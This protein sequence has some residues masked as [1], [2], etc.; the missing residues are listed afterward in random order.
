MTEAARR[1]LAAA[2]DAGMKVGT[3]GENLLIGS[4][5]RMPRDEYFALQDRLIEHQAEIIALLERGRRQ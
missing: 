5:L 3:D 1:A 2:V 4:S